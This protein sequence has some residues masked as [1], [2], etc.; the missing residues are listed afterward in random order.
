MSRTKRHR[1]NPS[2]VSWLLD[3]PT[4]E[5][6]RRF[7]TRLNPGANVDKII[8]RNNALLYCDHQR[9]MFT[10][11]LPRAH[12]RIGI[13]MMRR[14]ERDQLIRCQKNDTWDSHSALNRALTP[15]WY[16]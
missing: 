6:T 3:D 7:I 11:S 4:C 1:K 15:G 10:N 5:L 13:R 12:R 2:Y 9:R 16:W 14:R 8:E